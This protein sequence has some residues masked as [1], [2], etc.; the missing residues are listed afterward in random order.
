MELCVPSRWAAEAS[1]WGWRELPE[2]G[3]IC[4]TPAPLLREPRVEGHPDPVTTQRT[5][6]SCGPALLTALST[7]QHRRLPESTPL[8]GP[9]LR[10]CHPQLRGRETCVWPMVSSQHGLQ[11]HTYSNKSDAGFQVSSG[12]GFSWYGHQ[13]SKVMFSAPSP[14]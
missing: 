8:H 4:C 10:L 2:Q 11:P 14:P 1:C 12:E 7:F 9:R 3:S 5:A 6:I 13:S